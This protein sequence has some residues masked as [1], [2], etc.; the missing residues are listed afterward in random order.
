MTMEKVIDFMP[1]WK[2]E[3][4]CYEEAKIEG[5]D[6]LTGKKVTTHWTRDMPIE[7]VMYNEWLKKVQDQRQ[8]V[9]SQERQE[10]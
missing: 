4:K 7:Q 9:L 2:N 1:Y 10:R 5:K 8:E 3:E 6:R